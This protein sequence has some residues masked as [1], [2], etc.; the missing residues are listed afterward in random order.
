[1]AKAIQYNSAG[2]LEFLVD[3]NNQYYFMEM[4]TVCKEH[5]VTE[6]VTGIDIIQLQIRLAVSKK[7]NIKNSKM[8]LYSDMLLNVVSMRKVQ[9]IFY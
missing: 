3:K 8:S 6:L 7:L 9:R 4:N 2:T 5:T 1:M